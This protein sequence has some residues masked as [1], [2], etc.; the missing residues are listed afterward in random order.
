VSNIARNKTAVT[1]THYSFDSRTFSHCDTKIQN[2]IQIH[3]SE[4]VL[5][6]N[7]SMDRNEKS[8]PLLLYFKVIFRCTLPLFLYFKMIETFTLPLFL[9]FKVIEKFTLPL[10]LY[11]K[12]IE[13]FTLPLFLYFKVIETFTLPLFCILK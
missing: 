4:S 8:V 5:S 10:S 13:K 11:F 1:I 3:S 6:V 2:V 9:Y 7:C 12:M